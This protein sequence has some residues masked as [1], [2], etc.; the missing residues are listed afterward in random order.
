MAQAKNRRGTALSIKLPMEMAQAVYQQVRD[1]HFDTPGGVVR[2]A[3][4]SMLKLDDLGQ[5]LSDEADDDAPDERKRRRK[6]K[7]K[8][9]SNTAN[10][11]D[12]SDDE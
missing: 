11:P 10:T 1:G 12:D 7:Q 6:P 2:A 5:P 3:L 9:G 8:K 4:C